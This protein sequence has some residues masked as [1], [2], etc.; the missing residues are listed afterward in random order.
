M[1]CSN[2]NKDPL[3]TISHSQ[4]RQSYKVRIPE[5]LTD[6]GG[7][8]KKFEWFNQEVSAKFTSLQ[9]IATGS[10]YTVPSLL[11]K[12]EKVKLN[13]A[14]LREFSNTAEIIK[15]NYQA[16]NSRPHSIFKNRKTSSSM[17]VDNNERKVGREARVPPSLQECL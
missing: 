6:K 15:Q 7:K 8:I 12:R 1:T 4:E 3:K 14:K 13:H 10:R 2:W 9:A 5:Q 17:T 11:N 16:R